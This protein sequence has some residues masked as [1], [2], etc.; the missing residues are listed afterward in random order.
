MD[1]EEP[2][3]E[4]PDAFENKGQTLQTHVLPPDT[5]SSDALSSEDKLAE[6]K[7]EHVVG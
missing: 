1:Y 5:I 7:K 3:V 6:V 2:Q 4:A